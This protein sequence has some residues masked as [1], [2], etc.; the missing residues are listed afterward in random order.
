[1]IFIFRT[2]GRKHEETGT[3]HETKTQ[4][5]KTQASELLQ[6]KHNLRKKR[7][8]EI[9]KNMMRTLKSSKKSKQKLNRFDSSINPEQTNGSMQPI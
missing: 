8:Q 2:Q 3:K 6:H 1:M 7:S 5:K 4:Q 9:K